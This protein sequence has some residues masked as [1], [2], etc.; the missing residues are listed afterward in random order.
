MWNLK[1]KCSSRKPQFVEF[2]EEEEMNK[3]N[4]IL[5]CQRGHTFQGEIFPNMPPL[6]FK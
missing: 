1:K 5:H 3:D 2:D 4:F 6:S